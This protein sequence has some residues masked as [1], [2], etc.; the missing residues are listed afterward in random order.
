MRGNKMT[1]NL[2]S[3]SLKELRDLGAQVAKAIAT[4]EDRKKQEAIQVLEEKAKALGFSLSELAAAAPPRKPK[5]GGVDISIDERG[6]RI[7]M[8]ES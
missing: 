1:I 7:P 5:A 6:V 3:L 2:D 8:R 4:F